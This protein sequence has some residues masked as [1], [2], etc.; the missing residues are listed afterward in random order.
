[1]VGAAEDDAVSVGEDGNASAAD[2][3]GVRAGE[4][5]RTSPRHLFGRDPAGPMQNLGDPS[6]VAHR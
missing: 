1:M 2:A 6:E 4:D 3:R 5:F